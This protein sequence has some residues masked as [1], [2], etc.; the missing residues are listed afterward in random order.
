MLRVDARVEEGDRDSAPVEARQGDSGP[1]A[2][3]RREPA[4]LDQGRRD[5]GR[6]RDADRIDARD[7]GRAA[8]GSVTARGSSGAEKPVRTRA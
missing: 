2:G 1:G 5:G 6:V 3:A 8:R 4:L 7:L